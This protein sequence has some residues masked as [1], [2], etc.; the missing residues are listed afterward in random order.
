MRRLLVLAV[1]GL[2]LGAAP[3]ST[4]TVDMM[5]PSFAVDSLCDVP[6]PGNPPANVETLIVEGAERFSQN[7]ERLAAFY[8]RGR[9][10][11]AFSGMVTFPRNPTAIWALWVRTINRAGRSSCRSTVLL[12]NGTTGV[13]IPEPQKLKLYDVLGRRVERTRS[14]IYYYRDAGGERRLVYLK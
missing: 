10:G 6:A 5:L 11:Q 9:D 4:L 12:V 2:A 7:V 14:G 3:A 1:L 13:D 8:V